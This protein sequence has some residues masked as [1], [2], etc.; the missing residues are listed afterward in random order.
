MFYYLKQVKLS[1]NNTYFGVGNATDVASF[2]WGRLSSSETPI[3][4]FVDTRHEDQGSESSSSSDSPYPA[5]KSI[6]KYHNYDRDTIKFVSI[7]DD[8]VFVDVVDDV[9]QA[10]DVVKHSCIFVK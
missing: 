6:K 7:K 8:V 3:V 5:I 1:L 10:D 2:F 9:F 4:L